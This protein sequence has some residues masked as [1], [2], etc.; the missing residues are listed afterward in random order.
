[1]NGALLQ[2]G[3]QPSVPLILASREFVEAPASQTSEVI[4][5]FYK[6]YNLSLVFC[7]KHENDQNQ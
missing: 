1:M 2:L 5:E 6:T 4:T 3:A 7:W